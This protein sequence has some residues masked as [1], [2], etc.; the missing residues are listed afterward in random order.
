MKTKFIH[1]LFLAIMLSGCKECAQNSEYLI[2]PQDETAVL[3]ISDGSGG[4]ESHFMSESSN[5][6]IVNHPFI[7]DRVG[8]SLVG[9]YIITEP[10]HDFEDEAVCN[11]PN[12]F[13]LGQFWKY[14]DFRLKNGW[15]N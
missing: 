4:F 12:N 9:L 5:I 15:N 13:D 3:A 10:L 1:I 6:N 14:T 8:G 2:F 7:D 11:S